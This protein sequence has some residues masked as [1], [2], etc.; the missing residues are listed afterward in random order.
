MIKK[1]SAG[2]LYKMMQKEKEMVVLD[3][4]DLFSY[5]LGH[6]KGALSLPIDKVSKK[7]VK[8][9]IPDKNE[10]VVVY[11][12]NLQCVLSP[13]EAKELEKIGY[14]KLYHFAGGIQEW[15]DKGLPVQVT[16]RA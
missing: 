6:V 16:A 7:E 14:K 4:R 5:K 10:K 9:L 13:A 1:I 11:C 2:D 12:R 15:M 3:A 8:R